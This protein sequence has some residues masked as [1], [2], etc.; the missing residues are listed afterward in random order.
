M[1]LR[2][3]SDVHGRYD[4]FSRLCDGA[5]YVVQLGDFGFDYSELRKQDPNRVKVLL[6]NHDNYDLVE[7]YSDYFLGDFG[8]HK[9]GLW[10]FFSVRGAFSIDVK[11]RKIHQ[12][13]TKL[14]S[15]WGE[16]QL[17]YKQGKECLQDYK[18]YYDSS[19]FRIVFS[20]SCPTFVSEEVGKPDILRS[21]GYPSGMITSTQ[22]L[23]QDIYNY[24]SPSIWMFAHFH[25]N[26]NKE[27]DNTLF[28][29]RD[30]LGYIDFSE[31]WGVLG[32]G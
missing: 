20:H 21:F 10:K 15:W 9:I 32:Y 28:I 30:E 31:N 8:Q 1:K 18:D 25:I 12:Y 11:G 7:E 5:D 29:C 16:E 3:I 26:Y 4:A 17:N 24:G 23:L 6:G 14:K 22:E 13:Q 2:V 27:I 19:R